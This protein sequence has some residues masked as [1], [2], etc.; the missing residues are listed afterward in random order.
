MSTE[1][2][3]LA[4]TAH[5]LVTEAFRKGVASID[6]SPYEQPF[7]RDVDLSPTASLLEHAMSVFAEPVRSDAWLAPRLHSA[8]RLTRREA[9]QRGV[10]SY[11]GLVAFPHYVRW[12]FASAEAERFHGKDNNHALG[13]LWWTAEL[14][15][16]GP[17][18]TDVATALRMQDVPNTWLRLDA[19]HHRPT[20]IAAVRFMG[21]LRAGGPASSDEV[22][23]IAKGLNLELMTLA[24]DA[25]VPDSGPGEGDDAWLTEGADA[26]ILLEDALPVGPA[27]AP[28]DDDA[29]ATATELLRRVAGDVG[30]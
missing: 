27:D 9:A 6:F 28:V 2:K 26:A 25:S 21:G 29:I 24:L 13:R 1:L 11:L 7:D 8:L 30:L 23:L 16:N 17:D 14:V 18:Y 22:N 5:T 15:R 4:L 20:A 3:T 19:F 10:W 12:R